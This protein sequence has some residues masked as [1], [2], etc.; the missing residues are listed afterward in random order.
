MSG[1]GKK[2]RKNKW[3]GND[4]I[5]ERKT[6]I[7]L[8]NGEGTLEGTNERGGDCTETFCVCVYPRGKMTRVGWER[9]EK[10]NMQRKRI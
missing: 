5:E 3:E 7:G 2:K 10:Y 8:M 6:Y 9:D 4:L 1:K